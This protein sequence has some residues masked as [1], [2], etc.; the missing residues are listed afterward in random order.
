VNRAV[1]E[2]VIVLVFISTKAD[3]SRHSLN[4][5][6]RL[7]LVGLVVVVVVS[8]LA[9]WLCSRAART[10]AVGALAGADMESDFSGRVINADGA[11]HKLGDLL[12][13]VVASLLS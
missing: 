7:D 10:S 3:C 12:K 4:G 9:E 2:V 8:M 5:K 1:S 11:T 6:R 13:T